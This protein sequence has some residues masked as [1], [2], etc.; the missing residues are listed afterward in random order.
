[1]LN[2]IYNYSLKFLKLNEGIIHKMFFRVKEHVDCVQDIVDV[3][4]IPKWNFNTSSLQ[5]IIVY[6]MSM[7]YPVNPNTGKLVE[8]FVTILDQSTNSIIIGNTLANLIF[9]GNHLLE[10]IYVGRLVASYPLRSINLALEMRTS[11]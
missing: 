1:M 11:A 8:Q 4:T 10:G 9:D 6:F 2:N 7:H 3:R 5:H